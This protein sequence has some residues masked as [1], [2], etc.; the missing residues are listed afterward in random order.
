[1]DDRQ[2]VIQRWITK[3]FHDLHTA[4][5]MIQVNDVPADIVCF[6]CQQCAEKSLKAFLVFLDQA[7]PRTHDVV[8]LLALCQNFRES[9]SA[10][11]GPAIAL[12]D[13]AVEVRYPDDWREIPTEEASEALLNATRVLSFVRQELGDNDEPATDTPPTETPATGTSPADAPST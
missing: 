4:Q 12:A 5:T 1:M 3:A 6:H 10:L 9:F 7:P 2:L 11:E 8:K 13:Y